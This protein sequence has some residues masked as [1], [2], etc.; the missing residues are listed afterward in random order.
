MTTV[1]DIMTKTVLTAKMNT[2]F[3]DIVNALMR[4]KI[5]HL[6]ITNSDGTLRGIISAS[7]I[8]KA[9]HEM[10]QFNIYYNGY[11]LEK[12]LDVKEEMS[13]NFFSISS[14]SGLNEAIDL[15]VKNNIHA[16]PVIDDEGLVGM[17]TS[18]D[19]LRAIKKKGL[20][21]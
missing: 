20:F 12:R 3:E 11:S 15:L 5:N 21:T 10:D 19:I 2:P 14:S 16:L 8:L 9:M 18:N 17:L 7:D 4:S 6:P 13:S 1:N